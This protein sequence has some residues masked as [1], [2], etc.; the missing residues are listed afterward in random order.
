VGRWRRGL[1]SWARSCAGGE[2]LRGRR[3][4]RARGV[5][6]DDSFEYGVPGALLRV[7]ACGQAHSGQGF[8]VGEDFGDGGGEVFIAGDAAGGG[9]ACAED[10]GGA[11]VWGDDGGDAAGEGFEDYVAEGVGVGGKDEEVHVGVGLGECFAVED[12]GE[13]GVREGLAEMGFFGSVADDVPL[14]D[15][16]EGA[17]L[18]VDSGEEGYVLFYREAADVAEDDVAVMECASAL[19][20]REDAG[21]DAALH[22]VDGPVGGALEEAAELGVGS[23]DDFGL[24]VE[25][26]GGVEHKGFC[27]AF[28]FDTYGT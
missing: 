9:G 16:A 4:L 26:R 28:D 25:A 15:D 3:E 11:P 17:E 5:G 21:V 13:V 14:G 6:G 18:G 10:V 23:V 27:D 1:L 8:R 22:E 2:V 7:G 12:A 24:A 20:G 19:G